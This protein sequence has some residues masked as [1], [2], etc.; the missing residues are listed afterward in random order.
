M[1]SLL[2]ALLEALLEGVLEAAPCRS[3]LSPGARC[4]GR[5]CTTRLGAVGPKGGGASMLEPAPR[6]SG[7][8]ALSPL[9]SMRFCE[10]PSQADTGTGSA[11][12]P[13]FLSNRIKASGARH[14][15][16]RVGGHEQESIREYT[17][18]RTSSSSRCVQRPP[19]HP[20][21]HKGDLSPI[22]SNIEM[23][24]ERASSIFPRDTTNF[25]HAAQPPGLVV[26][27]IMEPGGI[28]Y[29]GLPDVS[30]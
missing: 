19:L 7:R 12:K 26:A 17:P 28:S 9:M 29:G 15:G 23:R 1:E 3:A 25:P 13:C 10:L 5:W 16:E 30:L 6:C 24:F 20:S 11:G 18:A 21:P 14:S 2:E 27:A 8:C 22:F 4:S